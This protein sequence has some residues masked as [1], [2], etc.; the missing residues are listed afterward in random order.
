MAT[1]GGAVA[2]G[3]GATCGSIEPGKAADL[4]CID[5]ETLPCESTAATGTS[6][7]DT[8]LFGASRG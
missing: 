5:L 7:A 1:L 6:L 8:L 4:V 2:L 3:L